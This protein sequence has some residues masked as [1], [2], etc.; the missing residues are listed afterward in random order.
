M[1]WGAADATA[2][3]VRAA[4]GAA[5][6]DE[7]LYGLLEI[8]YKEIRPTGP[9]QPKAADG[10]WINEWG[11]KRG[12]EHYGVALSAPLAGVETV[13]EVERHP[14]PDLDSYEVV[15]PPERRAWAASHC[16]I[17]GY[18]S[19]IFHDAAEL[20][21]MEDF[22]ISMYENEAVVH[23]VLE[24]CCQFYMELDRRVFEANPGVIDM[25]MMSS[26]FG[27]QRSLFMP[28]DMWR[29]FIKPYL[30]RIIGQARS[31]GWVT[32]LHSCGSIRPIIGDLIEIGVAAVNPIQVSAEDMDPVELV[33]EFR[34][35]MVFFGGIDEVNALLNGTEAQVRAETRRIID[36][37][38]QYGR[39][40][41]CAS[42]DFLLPEIPAQNI[43][44][45]YEEA[46]SYGKGMA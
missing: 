46:R 7:A 33:K 40:I 12:G 10:T 30:A 4:L 17:G 18:W 6:V 22:F 42:H 44:A 8:D 34:D 39:Y 32:A 21:G 35:E 11:V 14:S 16:V 19:P 23:A 20:M 31:F 41:A 5:T 27:T 28:P 9:P 45:M 38:G 2:E 15:I 3:N 36:T 29:E 37:L 24:K 43:I 13:A 26:D 1:W 25:Y